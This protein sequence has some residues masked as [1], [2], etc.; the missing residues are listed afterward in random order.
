VKFFVKPVQ[1]YGWF[2]GGK[3][4]DAPHPF[5]LEIAAIKPGEPFSAA[6]GK[7][8]TTGHTLS[9]KWILL[10]PRR[11]PYDGDCNLLAFADKPDIEKPLAAKIAVSGFASVVTVE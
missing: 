8:E 3:A 2:D 1:G 6:L 7:L 5:E 10:S 9:E 11:Q 4:I